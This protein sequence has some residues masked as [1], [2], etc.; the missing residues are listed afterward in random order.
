MPKWH[1]TFAWSLQ[2][3]VAAGATTAVVA[4][5]VA[6]AAVIIDQEDEDDDEEDP[7]AIAAEQVSQTHNQLPP[8]AGRRS[9]DRL[10]ISLYAV[11]AGWCGSNFVKTENI[12]GMLENRG[13]LCYS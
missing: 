2:A 8:F 7:R 4:R 9:V 12:F 1:R 13:V 11:G 3:G 5:R 10:S 6:A